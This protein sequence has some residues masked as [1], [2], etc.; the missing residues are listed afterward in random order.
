MNHAGPV[1][2]AARIPG[3]RAWR[4]RRWMQ[5]CDEALAHLHEIVDAE[6]DDERLASRV[7]AHLAQCVACTDHFD[8]VRELKIAVARVERCG[9]PRLAARLAELADELVRGEESGLR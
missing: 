8:A 7:Q 1:P 5:A 9:D 3:T 2:F 4:A 6:V